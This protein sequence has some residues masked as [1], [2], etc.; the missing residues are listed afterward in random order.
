MSFYMQAAAATDKRTKQGPESEVEKG[1]DHVLNP[2]SPRT[3]ESRHQYWRPSARFHTGWF[4][5]LFRYTLC[6]T[7]HPVNFNR[8]RR[9]QK[10]LGQGTAS[11]NGTV[12][13]YL[14]PEPDKFRRVFKRF[15]SVV[16]QEDFYVYEP[17]LPTPQNTQAA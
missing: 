15:G 4:L 16:E 1:E 12:F 9:L 8:P 13:V 17:P 10:R 3:K 7:D 2:P 5:P 14:G 11:P 6:F